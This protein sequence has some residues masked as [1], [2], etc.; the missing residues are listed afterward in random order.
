[1]TKWKI[2]NVWIKLIFFLILIFGYFHYETKISNLNIIDFLLYN[3]PVFI[4]LIM[5]IV[6]LIRRKGIPTPK[7]L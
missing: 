5:V 3:V 2:D 1:M 6:L 4:I 7:R